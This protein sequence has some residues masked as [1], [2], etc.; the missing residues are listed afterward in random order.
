M[1][2]TTQK[3]N[4]L[5][6]ARV[7]VLGGTSGVGYAVAEASVEFGASVVVASSTSTKVDDALSALKAAYPA[8][9]SA[10]KIKGTTCD[11]ADAVTVEANIK[12]LL[13]FATA[14]GQKIDHIVS[15]AGSIGSIVPLANFEASGAFDGV[16]TRYSSAL[17]L[18]KLGPS[19][20][21][22]GPRSSIT[23]TGAGASRKP[24][25]GF[26]TL[27]GMPAMQEGLMRGLAVDLAPI[28]VNVVAL[29]V[30]DTPIFR[31]YAPDEEARKGLVVAFAAEN[32]LNCIGKPE[33]VA[34]AYLYFMRDAFCTGHVLDTNGGGLLVGRRT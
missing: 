33:D 13:D 21:N 30:I 25:K 4:K 5:A 17:L 20:M 16:G 15:T 29:G 12:N 7:L 22:P 9:A 10:N 19:Y 24:A 2:T 28:R 11:L 3:Y 6:S 18:G 31:N 34:E 27:A 8:A 26:A 14:D 23:I 32:L 1:S